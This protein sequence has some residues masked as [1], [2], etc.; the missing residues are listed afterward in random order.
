MLEFL[1]GR[2][3]NPADCA[4]NLDKIFDKLLS[5]YPTDEINEDRKEELGKIL[6]INGYI[7][8]SYN[9]A[10]KELTPN[11]ILY[12]VRFKLKQNGVYKNDKFEFE[13]KNISPLARDG[14]K[15]ADWIKKEGHNIKFIC[16]SALGKSEDNEET[17]KFMDWL[18]QL[19]ILP[20]GNKSNN[21]Y[22]TT[23]YL[24]PFHPRDFGCAYLP[25][26]SDISDKLYDEEIEKLT[27][28]D[29]KSQV[30][31][32]ITLCQLSGHPVIY[33]VLPQTGRFSKEVLS[34]PEI[35]RWFDV[36][37]LQ[38]TI[39]AQFENI[40]NKLSDKYDKEDIELVKD[41]YLQNNGSG[42]LSEK[43]QEI[44]DDFSHELEEIKIKLSNDM[45]KKENQAKIHKRV[46]GFIAELLNVKS[47]TKLEENDIKSQVNIVAKLINEGLW[48]ACGGAWCS[49]GTPVFEQMSD[50]GDYPMFKHYDYKGSDVTELAN[51]DCQT[52]YYFTFLEDGTLNTPVVEYFKKHI[53]N[54]QKEYNFDGFRFDHTD[55]IVDK[56]SEKDGRPISYRLPRVVIKELN[57]SLKKQVPY[58]ATMAEYMLQGNYLEDYHKGMDF[59]V[60]WGNDIPLQYGKT[61]EKIDEDNKRLANYNVKY[62]QGGMLSILKTYNNQDGEFACIDQYP[63]Q[64]T[65]DGAL[66]KWFKLKFLSGGKFAQRPVLYVDGDESYTIKGIESIISDEISM[67]RGED[68]EFFKKFDAIDRFVKND[69]IIP[70]GEAQVIFEDEDGFVIWMI[71]KEPL[72]KS[73]LVAANYNN[74]SEKMV[75]NDDVGERYSIVTHGKDVHDKTFKLPGDYLLKGEYLLENDKFKFKSCEKLTSELVFD[76]LKPAQFKVFR[77]D[78]K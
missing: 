61:P 54:I 59:D 15:N 2:K 67:K 69:E 57:K 36:N 52:P 56:V 40:I 74:P 18:R 72:K 27:G 12:A 7:N 70:D 42:E 22:S 66:F 6:R 10:L 55:H 38:S 31:T 51:L 65:A 24:A 21:I 78:R 45:M 11:E 19:A 16:L 14:V 8:Y 63:G 68:E 4:E 64:L 58:F 9:R 48:P 17:G 35:A 77:L 46:R 47:G 73:Y 3:E 75:R 32:F 50:C 1:F 33:D 62:Q 49:A 44:Y 76:E 39:N 43:Y 37:I 60:L 5:K 29:K 30:K 53:L 20:T 28:M 41:I 13:D 34:H 23:I 71:S 25:R 26:S